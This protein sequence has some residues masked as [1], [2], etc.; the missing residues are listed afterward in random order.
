MTK[1]SNISR[2]QAEKLLQETDF[3]NRFIGISMN[4]SAGN[5]RT[6]LYSLEEVAKFIYADDTDVLLQ[7]GKSSITY[8]NMDNL[9]KWIRDVYEDHELADVLEEELNAAPNLIEKLKVASKRL[10]ERI[11]QC[12]EVLE[13]DKVEAQ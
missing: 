10:Q 13:E 1:L 12:Y 4:A 7:R 9:V 6:S 8:I 11:K 3:N 2:E 5:S